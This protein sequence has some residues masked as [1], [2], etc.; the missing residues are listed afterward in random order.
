MS[1]LSKERD[2]PQTDRQCPK[3]ETNNWYSFNWSL[4]GTTAAHVAH[5]LWM[6]YLADADE[7]IPCTTSRFNSY[8]SYIFLD[9]WT[10]LTPFP[11]SSSSNVDTDEQDIGFRD[12]DWG[13]NWKF[14][15]S[16]CL[17]LTTRSRS[18]HFISSRCFLYLES[19]PASFCLSL[20]RHT[21]QEAELKQYHGSR[22]MDHGSRG[23]SSAKDSGAK[24]R[25]SDHFFIFLKMAHFN[26]WK[27]TRFNCCSVTDHG[28]RI[29]DYGSRI[30]QCKRKRL[31]SLL[32]SFF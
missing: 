8:Y 29:A 19:S 27:M 11:A 15:H 6:G 16:I 22:I 10:P 23:S 3:T 30:V 4:F 31:G 7:T 24:E 1:S 20:F 14:V 25:D 32:H 21:T 17:C 9:K 28:S 13:N 18:R 12:A 5:Q 2:G 26:C